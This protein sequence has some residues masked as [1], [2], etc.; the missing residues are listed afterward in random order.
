MPRNYT[1]KEI[2]AMPPEKRRRLKIA[3]R[4]RKGYGN[5][6]KQMTRDE[7]IEWG[8][9]KGVKSSR[10]LTAIREGDEPTVDDVR[11]VFGK[12]S[13]FIHAINGTT[14]EP[15]TPFDAPPSDPAY[16]AR[17]ICEHNLWTASKYREARRLRP[18]IVPSLHVVFTHF[19]TWE[20]VVETARMLDTEETLNEYTKLMRRLGKPPTEF[21]C[22]K[23]N[24]NLA[25]LL[26]QHHTKK[27]LDEFA[28]RL[29]EIKRESGN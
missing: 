4:R 19:G 21:R 9:K 12:W 6:R 5:T 13:N 10:H 25:L 18:D 22:K 16:I 11:K 3:N 15:E 20:D 28:L 24:I 1:Y 17:V 2:I 29:I 26:R 23:E 14:P 8:R 7:M 27:A